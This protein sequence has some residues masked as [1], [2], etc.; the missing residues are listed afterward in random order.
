MRCIEEI[1]ERMVDDGS[2]RE[3]CHLA[4]RQGG[5]RFFLRSRQ[6]RGC[7]HPF[8]NG[9]GP[10]TSPQFFY[11]RPEMPD[12]G[13]IVFRTKPEVFEDIPL[14]VPRLFAVCQSVGAGQT[15]PRFDD[16]MGL[17]QRQEIRRGSAS[18]RPDAAGYRAAA[19]GLVA[20]SVCQTRAAIGELD[21][22]VAE[23]DPHIAD[24][25]FA[26]RGG[27]TAR[28]FRGDTGAACLLR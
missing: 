28:N 1:L 14:D 25:R 26:R 2:R 20:E 6:I 15:D 4:P 5:H 27:K 8:E 22:G 7:R 11:K 16:I 17:E 3:E 10:H 9:Q 13:D 19:L 24:H 18:Q 12:H 21:R 23:A